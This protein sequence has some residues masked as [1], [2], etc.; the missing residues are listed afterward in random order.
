[1]AIALLHRRILRGPPPVIELIYLTGKITP[2]NRQVEA[3]VSKAKRT[4]AMKRLQM[5]ARLSRTAL[6][7]RLLDHGF[8]PGQDQIMLALEEQ[9]GCTPGQLAA[10]LGVRPPTIA[11]AV[12]RLQTQGSLVKR[13]S[14]GDGRQAHIWLTETGRSA[15]R[16]IGRAVVKT[17]KQA[18]RGLDKKEQ[19]L[20]AK[21]LSRVEANLSSSE[22]AAMAEEQKGQGE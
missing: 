6:A 17:D 3:A 15:L 16:A 4:E 7:A 10:Q 13:A 19:K 1:M 2:R 11:K 9:D 12:N 21:L 18:M 20:L 22:T 14:D 5:T 8:Y